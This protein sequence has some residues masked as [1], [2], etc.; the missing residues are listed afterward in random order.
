MGV[1]VSMGA[2]SSIV[3]SLTVTASTGISFDTER[4][5]GG[6]ASG[7]GKGSPPISPVR[8]EHAER[9]APASR[10]A[11]KLARRVMEANGRRRTGAASTGN[12]G[13]AADQATVRAVAETG[14]PVF[15]ETVELAMVT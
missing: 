3:A 5:S 7:S 6:A 9:E 4:S 1:G 11:T 12:H 13:P 10:A 14:K 2:G 8:V 15:T